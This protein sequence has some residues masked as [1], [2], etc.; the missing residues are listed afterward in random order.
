MVGTV[1]GCNTPPS[2]TVQFSPSDGWAHLYIPPTYIFALTSCE[3][4]NT[5]V[6]QLE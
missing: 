5:G 4:V 1:S 3:R 6:L 2:R